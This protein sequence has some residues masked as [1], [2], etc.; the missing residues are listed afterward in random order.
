MA[1]VKRFLLIRRLYWTV[2]TASRRGDEWTEAGA[3]AEILRLTMGRD[4]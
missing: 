4:F 2:K 1:S 3:R